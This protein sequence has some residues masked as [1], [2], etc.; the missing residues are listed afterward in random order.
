ME[1]K[2]E[3]KKLTRE[4]I[5]GQISYLNNFKENTEKDNAQQL[6]AL[7]LSKKLLDL[8]KDNLDVIDGK[9]KWQTMRE[10]YEITAEIDALNFDAYERQINDTISR[11]KTKLEQID[12]EIA[13]FKEMD[14]E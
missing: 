4:E 5:E 1:E 13:K 10:Y 9:P 2:M 8:K 12:K 7:E 11:N 6:K 14:G 3:E